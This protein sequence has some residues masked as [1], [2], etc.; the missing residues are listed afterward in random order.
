LNSGN[1]SVR[2]VDLRRWRSVV[3]TEGNRLLTTGRCRDNG[4]RSD[5]DRGTGLRK[6]R[7]RTEDLC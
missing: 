6:L 3:E 7:N 2:P 1:F 5:R 4:R